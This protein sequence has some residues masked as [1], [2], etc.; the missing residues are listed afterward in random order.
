MNLWGK[1]LI[2]DSLWHGRLVI[3]CVV[4]TATIG[5]NGN[6]GSLRFQREGEVTFN[7]Q[8]VAKGEIIF[9]PDREKGG[10]GPGTTVT[11]ENGRY[12]TR[13][14]MGALS[15]PHIVVISGYNGKPGNVSAT[16]EPHPWGATLFA[17]RQYEIDFPSEASTY[18]FHVTKLDSRP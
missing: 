2:G 15:G 8:P 5:C 9:S 10:K 7:G 3:T 16:E 17:G 12:Q 4:L 14:E 18:D 6:E 11:F 1:N 13:E